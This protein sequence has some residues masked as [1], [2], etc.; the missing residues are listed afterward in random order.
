MF[1]EKR[2]ND[3]SKVKKNMFR[4]QVWKMW[5]FG[6]HRIH[7]TGIFTYMNGW[8]LWYSWI[9]KYTVRPMDPLGKN[10]HFN[11]PTWRWCFVFVSISNLLGCP[12]KLVTIVSKLGYNLL[13]GLE[14][15]GFF[16]TKN[17]GK[18]TQIASIFNRVFH[19]FHHPFWGTPIFGNIQIPY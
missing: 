16:W 8:F 5:I 13:T 7:G 10:I 3:F 15:N 11:G 4:F 6:T 19:Y 14:I 9:G 17:M 18:K 1:F 12:W 2:G